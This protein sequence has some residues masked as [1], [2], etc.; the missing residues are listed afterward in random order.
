M[1]LKRKYEITEF[2]RIL[3]D[4][5]RKLRGTTNPPEWVYKYSRKKYGWKDNWLD[6]IMM[7]LFKLSSRKVYLWI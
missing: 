2:E 1:E 7:S 5:T 6:I 4:V 3:L